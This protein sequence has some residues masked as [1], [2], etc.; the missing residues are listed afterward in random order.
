MASLF[1]HPTVQAFKASQRSKQGLT[2]PLDAEWL[3]TLCLEAGA[4]DVGFV[5]IDRAEIAD[6]RA[7]ILDLF[8]RTKTLISL[9][10]RMNRENIRNPA[11]S[12]ANSE[13]HHTGHNLEEATRHIV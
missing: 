1:E 6:Q 3:R 8:P 9:V 5:E 10:G 12:L 11:R 4:D 2:E 7:E 13:F